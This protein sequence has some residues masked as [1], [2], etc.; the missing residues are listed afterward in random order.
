MSFADGAVSGDF[1]I[2][3]QADGCLPPGLVGGDWWAHLT[4][5]PTFFEN[6]RWAAST[7]DLGRLVSMGRVYIH[8]Q[9]KISEIDIMLLYRGTGGSACS[10][11]GIFFQMIPVSRR[12]SRV[13]C[14]LTDLVHS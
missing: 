7:G 1:P 2:S 13:G 9:K 12:P 10:V 8:P 4:P 14:R 3:F 11:M 5:T 6:E